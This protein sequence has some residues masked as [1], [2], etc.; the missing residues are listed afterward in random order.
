MNCRKVRQNLFGY[1]KQ[2]LSPEE[3]ERIKAHL[4]SCPACAKEAEEIGEINFMLKDGLETFVPSADFNQKLL[5]KIQTITS[6][7]KIRDTRR[8]WEKLLHEVFPS[9]RLRWALVGTVSV[10]FLAW[11]TT[12]FTQKRISVGPESFTQNDKQ[13][14]N[15][16][17][18]SSQDREDSSFQQVLEQLTETS[19]MKN[20][21]Y[22]IDNFSLS[23]NRGED[24]RIRPGDMHRR[25]VIERS[26]YPALGTGRGNHYV[27]PVV[28]TQPASEKT[29]Y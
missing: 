10:I 3:T 28:S 26:S 23:S 25:F 13:V 4:N 1:Y 8:W 14:E 18:V 20:R 27:L 19:A 5:A 24:G 7:V 22:V 9:L 12:M 2:E 15:Q 16:N 11:V 29:D 6:D 21:A 17:L